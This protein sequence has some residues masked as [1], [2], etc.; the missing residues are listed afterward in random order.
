MKGLIRNLLTLVIFFS[1]FLSGWTP[2]WQNPRIPLKIQKVQAAPTCNAPTFGTDGG[3]SNNDMSTTLSVTGGCSSAP[4]CYTTD[5]AT[6]GAATAGTCDSD[7]HTQTYS[8]TVAVTSTGTVVKALSTKSGAN[9]SSVATSNVFTLTVGAITSSPGAGSYGSTQSVTLN[10]A[11]TTGATAH[12]T[13]D[14]SAVDCSS[15]TYSGPFDVSTT[16]TVKAIGC[17]TNYVSNSPISDLYTIAAVSISVSTDGSV[18]FDNRVPGETIDTTAGG[19]ND[20]ETINVDSGPANLDVKTTVFSEGGNN[21][22]LG[23]SSNGPTQVLWEFSKDGSNW[24]VF[25]DPDPSTFSLD[26]NV[27]QGQT[28]NLYLRLTMPTTTNS[29][30]QYSTSVTI[31]A[32]AP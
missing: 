27:A 6:P 9:N 25:T 30:N 32:S 1:W 20:P 18:S 12:Y 16:T 2:I 28:R 13:T 7:G 10:I 29:Y 23:T 5:G 31:V 21:W 17:K 3:S 8:G 15:T 19:I 22:T 14:G 4:I 26:T 24:T 11:D